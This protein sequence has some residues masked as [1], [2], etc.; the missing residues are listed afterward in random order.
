MARRGDEFKILDEYLLHQKTHGRI[1]IYGLGGCGKSALAIEFAY[2]TLSKHARLILWVPAIS[3]ATFELAYR[4]IGI[5]LHIPDV[6]DPNAD[7]KKLVRDVK[8]L[9]RDALSSAD[10]SR[11]LMIV[12]NADDHDV[13]LAN[14]TESNGTSSRLSDYLPRSDK[15]AI[16]FTT[17]SRK[18]A[19]TLTSG[20]ML[21]L[22]TLD[23]AG[24]KELLSRRLIT[25][26]SH[27]DDAS[28]EGL[29]NLL[30]HL[31]LAIVQA[32][33]FMNSNDVSV[34][35]YVQLLQEADAENELLSESFVDQGRYEGL[36]STIANTWHISF[37]QIRKYD[38]SAAELLSLIAC[39][40]R[41]NIPQSLLARNMPLVQQ[42][43]AL[44]T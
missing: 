16:L 21:A 35:A 38:P 15:G 42:T 31:P 18:M 39:I 36:D 7:V 14:A 2:R 25:Q 29:L 10:S 33:A 22:S 19:H 23:N 34:T 40:D 24:T 20:A 9:V 30:T 32:A 5:R 8:K 4:D 12:D 17:R 37:E 26:P 27:N 41:V 6:T 3:R 44:G 13:L 11:W 43:K 28:I 1:A